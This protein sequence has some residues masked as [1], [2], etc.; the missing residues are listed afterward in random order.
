MLN[1]TADPS[2]G[3]RENR[4]CVPIPVDVPGLR[5]VAEIRILPVCQDRIR[6]GQVYVTCF[7]HYENVCYFFP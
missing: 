5:P 6:N 3:G 7:R 4:S 2:L 1:N